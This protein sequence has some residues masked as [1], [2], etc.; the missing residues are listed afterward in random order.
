MEAKK[1]QEISSKELSSVALCSQNTESSE[2]AVT[3]GLKQ[4]KIFTKKI[5][6]Y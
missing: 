2:Q 4:E 5:K 1:I 6:F 3:P